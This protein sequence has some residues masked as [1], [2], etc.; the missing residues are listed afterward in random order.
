MEGGSNYIDKYLTKYTDAETDTEFRNRK[1]I[2]YVPKFAAAN[3]LEIRN[4][5]FQRIIDVKRTGGPISYGTAVRGEQS[6]IDN[7]GSS[8]NYFIGTTILPEMLAMGK[9]GVLIDAGVD[10]GQTLADISTP[11]LIPY[12]AE[13]IRSWNFDSTGELTAILLRETDYFLEEDLPSKTET[14]YRLIKKVNNEIIYTVYSEDEEIIDTG[15]LAYKKIPFVFFD[16]N[17]SLLTDV[18][19]YQRALLN[20]AS[21]D[22]GF[23]LKA[24][25]PIYT[26]MV[27][28][29][30]FS[31]YI[32]SELQEEDADGVDQDPKAKIKKVG[33]DRGVTY[34]KGLERPA[35]I[36][37][38]PEI[39]TTSIE[40]QEK[41]KLEIR[42]L[43][44]LAVSS[45]EPKSQSAESKKEDSRGLEA[46]LSY[47][48]LVLQRGEQLISDYWSM[49]EK[50]RDIAT[51]KYPERYTLRT[52]DEIRGE[53]KEL[54]ESVKN[55]PSITAKKELWKR[56]VDLELS[57][58]VTY[59][60]L[61]K[62]YTEIDSTNYPF[63]D[64]DSVIEAHREG[65]VSDQTASQ[66]LG[67]A[68]TEAE[69]AAK[70]HADRATRILEAQVSGMGDLEN[71]RKNNGE[72]D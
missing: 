59:E 32:S 41:L 33:T 17:I 2:A 10:R 36:G 42:Q 9:M 58:K 69:Q 4:A 56:I 16:I 64:I 66:S 63:V 30:I 6:G 47:I 52:E 68:A 28:G 8:L 13:E 20:I 72:G 71:T 25:V 5:I 44:H 62:I 57:A 67:Y 26:E 22:T 55:T 53:V 34:G 27:D 14:R 49:I 37:P 21:S 18:A 29:T 12:T 23:L 45:I 35:F 19:D 46:G 54:R 11:Y 1:T 48:A 31:P 61:Q 39:I 50:S 65:L 15:T 43:M 51:I 40:K 24:N 70:D 60:T 38:P 3:I 7:K